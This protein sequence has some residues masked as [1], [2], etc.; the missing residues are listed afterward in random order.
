MKKRSI[1]YHDEGSV[2]QGHFGSLHSETEPRPAILLLHE[3]N[4]LGDHIKNK[5]DE[6][7]QLGYH[8]FAADLY[9]KDVPRNFGSGGQFVSRFLADPAFWR[10]RVALALSELQKIPGVDAARIATIGYCIGGASALE[11]ARSG[12][13]I[14]GAVCIHGTLASKL[15]AKKGDTKARVLVIQGDSDPFVDRN[16]VEKFKQEMRHAQVNWRLSLIG[17]VA[18][19]FTNP[20][21]GSNPATG[22]AYDVTADRYSFNSVRYFLSEIFETPA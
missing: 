12:A 11:L 17:G 16:E 21:V 19:S 2:F 4:G 14:R 3:G 1:I 7:A 10:K 18:H 22:S 9:G 20:A 8:V 6:F 5:A 15:P 13:S